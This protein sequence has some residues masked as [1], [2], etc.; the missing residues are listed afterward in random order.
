MYHLLKK[1]VR[2]AEL[3]KD[4]VK[5]FC[6]KHG[7][8]VIDTN[9]RASRYHK[10][11]VK[12]FNNPTDYNMMYQDIVQDSEPLYTVEIAESELTR[13]AE[14]EAQVFNNMKQ[15]GHHNMF[16]ILMEQKQNEKQLRD[17]HVAVKKAYEHYSL[18]LS[19]ANSGRL[20]L[21]NA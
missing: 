12:Y 18:M 20:E 15:H 13:I 14:F 5:D 11:N 8:T 1:C 3:T 7:I 2:R 4:T 16:E 6:H 9:K 10:V 21:P 19:L 17:T